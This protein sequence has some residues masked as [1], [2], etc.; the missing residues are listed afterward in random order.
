[1]GPGI[2]PSGL[3]KRASFPKATGS[4]RFL[5]AVGQ[6]EDSTCSKSGVVQKDA[7][8]VQIN[9]GDEFV[10]TGSAPNPSFVSIKAEESLPCFVLQ[11]WGQK[12]TPAK[13]AGVGDG[14]YFDGRAR[15]LIG[16]GAGIR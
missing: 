5:V 16:E 15:F 10:S 4:L 12:N 14:A 8:R 2:Y 7:F 3:K 11:G 9:H 1:M 6:L 13:K